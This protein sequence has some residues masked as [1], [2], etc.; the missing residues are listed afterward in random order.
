MQEHKLN[1]NSL[2][3][4]RNFSNS[5]Y[6][7]VNQIPTPP[8]QVSTPHVSSFW[9]PLSFITGGAICLIMLVKLRKHKQNDIVIDLQQL[10][11]IP[12]SNCRFFP[13]ILILGAQSILKLL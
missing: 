6:I 3:A 10:N 13:A 12:C 8:N 4:E 11:K 1:Q 7:E 9:G 2:I 5:T